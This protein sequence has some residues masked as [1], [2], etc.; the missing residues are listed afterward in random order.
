MVELDIQL[1]KDGKVVAIHDEA[2][3]RTTDGRGRVVDHTLR[4]IRKL[5]AG[6]WFGRQFAGEK[7]PTL[8]EVLELA[9]GKVLVNVEIKH[10]GHGQYPI[11]ELADQGLEAVKKAGMLNRVLFSSFNPVSLERIRKREPRARTA[12]LYHHGWNSPADLPG[13]REF[14]VLNLRNSHLTKRKIAGIQRE[15]KRVNVYTVNTEEE[16]EQ[17]VSWGVDGIITNHPDR[18]IRILKKESP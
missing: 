8:H 5:D 10:P 9:K 18:L 15:G 14:E 12:F 17:F 1:S 7:I 6:A 13:F 16:L 2:L 4:E 11:A 3:D